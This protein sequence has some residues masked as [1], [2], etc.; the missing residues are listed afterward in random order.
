MS[1][2]IVIDGY[3]L[4]R[5]S[6]RLIGLEAIS[7]E[8]GRMGLVSLLADYR[9]IKNMP[10]TVVFDG[11]K[12]DNIG[13]SNDRVHGIDIIYSGKGDR[14]DN[15]IKRMSDKMRDKIIVVTSDKDIATHVN[16]KGSAV[17]PSPE[18]EMKVKMTIGSED[19]FNYDDE[20]DHEQAVGTRKKGPSK[21]L[22]KEERRKK[23]K[24]SKL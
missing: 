4:I 16:K 9:K 2:I 8:E 5:Q 3:N 22:S 24:L 23:N 6:D 7:L 19:C 13:S 10:I 18:F 21:R 12:S 1:I 20:D 14:A 15:V 17:I 11:W